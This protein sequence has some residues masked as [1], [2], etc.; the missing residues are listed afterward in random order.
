MDQD[1]LAK[2]NNINHTYTV[3][4]VIDYLQSLSKET[5]VSFVRLFVMFGDKC[6]SDG[7]KTR[8]ILYLDSLELQERYDVLVESCTIS[9]NK[10]FYEMENALGDG[11]FFDYVKDRLSDD[12]PICQTIR[13]MYSE[14]N[15]SISYL[16]KSINFRRLLFDNPDKMSQ[17]LEHILQVA[18]KVGSY[19]IIIALGSCLPK[20]R[21]LGILTSHGDSVLID[22]FFFLYKDYPE[23][24]NLTAFI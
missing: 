12:N 20:K 16:E 13:E 10:I 23:I 7:E 5:G 8:F 9:H 11:E 21:I 22:K 2:V 3:W 18:I 6:V 4:S 14:N 19:D 24:K 17:T 15:S 1:I